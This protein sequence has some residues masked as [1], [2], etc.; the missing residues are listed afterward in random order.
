[1]RRVFSRTRSEAPFLFSER[2]SLALTRTMRHVG[3]GAA[4][5]GD[6]DAQSRLEL[7]GT[8]EDRDLAGRSFSDCQGSGGAFV[9]L[10]LGG[11]AWSQYHFQNTRFEDR[12]ST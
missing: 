3:G 7:R 9:R 8:Y 11:S 6:E 4:D 2:G 5:F 1:M 10:A 12:K